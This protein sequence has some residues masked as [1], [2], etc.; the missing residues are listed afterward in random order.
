MK[1]SIARVY[2]EDGNEIKTNFSELLGKVLTKVDLD[3]EKRYISFFTRDNREYMMYHGQDCCESVLIDD[4]CGDLN[5]LIGSVILQAEKSST[6]G[7]TGVC[8]HDTWTFYRI[9]TI[10]G[11]VV[12]RWYG[13]S[14]GYY[15]E[16]VDFALL[17]LPGKEYKPQY[18]PFN[19]KSTPGS[20]VTGIY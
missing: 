12:I 16:G 1:E 5:D 8:D 15:S 10:K 7:E 18:K 3:K 20:F 2:G 19:Y 4:I 11:Q 17:P 14:N 6:S 13:S 9:A